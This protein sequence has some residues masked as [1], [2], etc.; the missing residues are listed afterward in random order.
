MI[1]LY[2]PKTYPFCG[3]DSFIKIGYD[4]NGIQRYKYQC[5]KKFKP[6]TGTILDSR[7]ISHKRMDWVLSQHLSVRQSYVDSWNNC[8]AVSTSKYWLEKLFFLLEKHK[9][10]LFYQKQTSLMTHTILSLCETESMMRT[11]DYS[12]CYLVIKAVSESQQI[13]KILYA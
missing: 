9:T 2:T 1:D 5:G 8:N 12:E 7:K 4:P 6:T 13:R 10:T 11:G 3:S